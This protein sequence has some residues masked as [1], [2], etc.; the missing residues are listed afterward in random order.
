MGKKKKKKVG[1]GSLTSLVIQELTP[2]K[3]AEVSL[4]LKIK[5]REK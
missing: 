2:D 1:I 3:T 5:L 4:F